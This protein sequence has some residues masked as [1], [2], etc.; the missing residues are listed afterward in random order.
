MIDWSGEA[1]KI[2]K[3]KVVSHIR[4][5]D[6]DETE[7]LMFDSDAPILFFT[8]GSWMMASSDDEVNDSGA[9]FT[10][11]DAMEIIPRGGR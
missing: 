4:Y 11:D 5:T 2:F 8:D 9:F 6:T 7:Q 1:T 10:S 3:G